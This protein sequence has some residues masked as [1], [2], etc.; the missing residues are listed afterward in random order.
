MHQVFSLGED[1]NW[2]DVS[3]MRHSAIYWVL[4]DEKKDNIHLTHQVIRALKPTVKAAL[5]CCGESP[6]NAL[7]TISDV[8]LSVLPLFELTSNKQAIRYLP[9]DLTRAMHNAAN[10]YIFQITAEIWHAFNSEEL[11]SWLLHIKKWVEENKSTLLIICYSTDVDLLQKRLG[12]YTVLLGGLSRVHRGFNQQQYLISWWKTN[13]ELIK[14][15]TINMSSDDDNKWLLLLDSQDLTFAEGQNDELL[16]FAEINVIEGMPLP[17]KQWLMIE[18]NEKLSK[19]AVQF[20]AATVLF[21][22]L[23]LEQIEPL[24]RLIYAVRKLCGARLKI[25][26]RELS[27]WFRFGDTQLLLAAGANLVIPHEVSFAKFLVMMECIKGQIYNR[28]LVDDIDKLLLS[29]RP[30][31]YKG[32]ITSDIFVKQVRARINNPWLLV[33]EKGV[34]FVI[35]AKPGM[36]ASQIV[37]LCQPVRQG[38]IFTVIS[39]EVYIFLTTCSLSDQDIA[40]ETIFHLPIAELCNDYKFLFHDA[41]ILSCLDDKEISATYFAEFFTKLTH[42]EEVFNNSSHVPCQVDLLVEF[43]ANE[44]KNA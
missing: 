20:S 37:K 25:V 35:K 13:Y 6:E 7:S 5:I 31:P 30:A 42:D 3:S 21:S 24:A 12:V 29:V 9:L 44:G 18:G 40:I 27:L 23:D 32:F 33:N 1:G 38:D 43:E 41:Q 17:N 39:D 22:L 11:E 2:F 14:N 10:F 8:T 26:V 4:A 36:K 28:P 16:F 15:K 19:M 34:M